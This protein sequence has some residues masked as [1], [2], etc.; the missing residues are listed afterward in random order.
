MATLLIYLF[1]VV[2]IVLFASQNLDMV[3]VHLIAG[4]PV[5]VPLIV[6]IGLSFFIGFVTAIFSVIIRT[7]R[8]RSKQSRYTRPPSPPQIR[9]M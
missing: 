2:G 9:R 5:E 4:N 7:L 1:L 3:Q 6:V 8:D